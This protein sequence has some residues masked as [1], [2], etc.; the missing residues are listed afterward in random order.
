MFQKEQLSSIIVPSSFEMKSRVA[1][2]AA[3]RSR[4]EIKPFPKALWPE[5]PIPMPLSLIIILKWSAEKIVSKIRT[6]ALE[7]LIALFIY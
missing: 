6:V 4:I 3:A 7:C 1:P 2:I 5:W